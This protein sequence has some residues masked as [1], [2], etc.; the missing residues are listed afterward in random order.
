MQKLVNAKMGFVPLI[1]AP[2]QSAPANLLRTAMGKARDYRDADGE[3]DLASFED[4]I[5]E[6]MEFMAIRAKEVPTFGRTSPSLVHVTIPGA[7]SYSCRVTRRRSRSR[8][9]T[10]TTSS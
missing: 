3:L 4:A 9:S 5:A 10:T 7:R 1:H 8:T 6:I 2:P